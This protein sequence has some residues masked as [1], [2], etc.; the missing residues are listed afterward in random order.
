M[1]RK[2][3]RTR[4]RPR[5][6]RPALQIEQAAPP[7]AATSPGPKSRRWGGTIDYGE[8]R[9]E[10]WGDRSFDAQLWVQGACVHNF[11]EIRDVD[12]ALG[13]V[14]DLL[15]CGIYHFNV[16]YAIWCCGELLAAIQVDRD[17]VIKVTKLRI[18]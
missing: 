16:D 9:D 15:E 1:A 8:W 2:Q 3:A 18:D 5:T 6:T 4:T 7:A 14:L 10:G 17:G 13:F 11:G 12:D